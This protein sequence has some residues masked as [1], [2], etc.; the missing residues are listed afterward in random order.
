MLTVPGTRAGTTKNGQAPEAECLA[1]KHG[2]KKAAS[3]ALAVNAAVRHNLETMLDVLCSFL[4]T[5]NSATLGFPL[6]P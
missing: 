6:G 5:G 4:I 2:D 1:L 3:T